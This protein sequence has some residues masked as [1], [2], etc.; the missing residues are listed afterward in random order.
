MKF[1]KFFFCVCVCVFKWYSLVSHGRI[2]TEK[3]FLLS[4]INFILTIFFSE[5]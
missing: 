5:I 4:V 3:I 1:F 2:I